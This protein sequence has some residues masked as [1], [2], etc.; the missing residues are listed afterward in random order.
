M[1]VKIFVDGVDLFNESTALLIGVTDG[2]KTFPERLL[3]SK[4][5]FQIL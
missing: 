2:A 5:E 4:R 1:G 3:P